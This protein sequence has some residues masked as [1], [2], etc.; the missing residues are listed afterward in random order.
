[1]ILEWDPTENVNVN[2][3]ADYTRSR[4]ELNLG[5]PEA[6]LVSVN[7]VPGIP[8][9][10]LQ[11]APTTPWNNTVATSFTGNEGQQMDNWGTALTVGWQLNDAWLLK[12]ITAYRS[13]E[14]DN[15]VDIDASIYELGDVFV[16]V[17]QDQTSQE[18]QLLYSS[19]R[20]VAVMGLYYFGEDITS[21]QTAW[22]DDFL[23]FGAMPIT[24]TRTVNDKLN[25][26]SY[27][28]FG[29]ATWSFTDRWSGTL[30]IRYT[31]ESKDYFRTTSTFF[32]APL[33]RPTRHSSTRTTRAGLRWTPTFALD[34]KLTDETLLY[35]SA[36]EGF[37]SGGFNGRAN[38]PGETGSYDPEYVW[39]YEIGA[40]N[41]LADGRLRLNAD[42]F[43]SDYTDFQARVSDVVDPDAPI[44]TFSFPVLNAG[45]MEM[46]GAELEATWI[47]IDELNLQAQIG[48]LHSDYK[49]FT[50]ST[51]IAG[52]PVEIDRSDEYP[53]FAPEWTARLAVAYTFNLAAKWRTDAVGRHDLS[54]QAVALGGQPRRADA[55]QLC[56]DE[57]ARELDVGIEPLVRLRRRQEP[58]RRGLQGGR[59]GVLER[60]QHP[61]R[62]LRRSADLAVHRRLSLLTIDVAGRPVRPAT[63]RQDTVRR[64]S[65][66]ARAGYP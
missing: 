40:K 66:E 37:K 43:Y 51:V 17:D 16:G 4:N 15:Y 42:V 52:K 34:Y 5:R 38:T 59:A 65:R 31:D 47:P 9:K 13:L 54:R 61:D 28:V 63:D 2:L 23:K 32:G 55:G 30:G 26:D 44:P 56:A 19:D 36:T 18:F 1:M 60:R 14:P 11:P 24:F 57:C 10:V 50:A 29:Q 7:L 27:A 39:T 8:P 46:Y 49:E 3:A 12:S 33:R 6:P 20:L 25:T 41:T 53:P 58:D 35:A 21:D 62:L 45:S 64:L 22:A 48:Y